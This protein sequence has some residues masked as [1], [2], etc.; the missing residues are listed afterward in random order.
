MKIIERANHT[1]RFARRLRFTVDVTRVRATRR[2]LRGLQICRHAAA[3][4]NVPAV[5]ALSSR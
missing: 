3:G 4:V 1:R 2:D 5:T